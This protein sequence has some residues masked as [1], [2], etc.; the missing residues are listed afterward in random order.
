MDSLSRAE[1]IV[2]LAGVKYANAPE[3]DGDTVNTTTLERIRYGIH[4]QKKTQL[5]ILV[6]G[7][8]PFG[9]SPEAEIMAATIHEDFRASVRWIE[10]K[11]RDT[12]EN[13]EFFAAI[14]KQFGITNIALVSQAWH[15]P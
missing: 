14:L 11:S 6:T 9:G 7:G 4:L 5:P 10:N 12:S 3:Y 2:I 1:A 13:A 15:L 8:A